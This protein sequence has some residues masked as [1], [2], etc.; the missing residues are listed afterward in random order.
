MAIADVF[1]TRHGNFHLPAGDEWIGPSMRS[2]AHWESDILDRMLAAL[3]PGGVYVDAGSFVGTHAIPMARKARAALAFEPQRH[4]FQMLCTNAVTNG[5]TNL[6]AFNAALGHLDHHTISMNGTVPDGV[7]RGQ[8]LVYGG[9]AAPINFGGTN[10]GAG[11][12]VAEMRTLDS[13]FAQLGGAAGGL[14]VLKVDVQG[15]EP[16]MFYGARNVISLYK[17]TIFYEVDGRFGVTADMRA[18]MAIP[19][20]V[21]GFDIAAFCAGLGYGAP[22]QLGPC[23][24]VLARPDNKVD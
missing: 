24:W 4:I 9:A 5:V 7:S 13:V 3:P 6:Y 17:P 2:G 18:Q 23:D 19:D 21:A 20:A 14:D 16:L 12:D 8:P 15:A 10:I 22:T 1:Y 11:G